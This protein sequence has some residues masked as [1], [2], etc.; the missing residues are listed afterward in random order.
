MAIVIPY[1]ATIAITIIALLLPCL[2][3]MVMIIRELGFSSLLKMLAI[4]FST[5]F[6]L[7]FILNII[8]PV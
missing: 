6:I 8:L 3:V 1:A 4:G 5:L 7:G 2:L